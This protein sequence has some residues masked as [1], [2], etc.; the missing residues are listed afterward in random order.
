MI[1]VVLE[2]EAEIATGVVEQARVAKMAAKGVAGKQDAVFGQPG[3]LRVGPVQ[4][5]RRDELQRPS[6]QIHRFAPGGNV[7][8]LNRRWQRL[9]QRF[10]HQ[11]CFGRYM[12]FGLRRAPQQFGQRSGM[13]GFQMVHHHRGDFVVTRYLFQFGEERLAER[14]LDGVDNGNAVLTAHNVSV[15][16][17]AVGGVQDEIELP[18]TR[19]EH[20]DPMHAG[21]EFN[22][23]AVR[24]DGRSGWGGRHGTRQ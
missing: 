18:Q 11:R 13:V 19:I 22:R 24:V 16:G 8:A 3:A 21:R 14:F 17:G 9:E 2:A 10:Q 4:I 1:E 6:T 20:A 7:V 15:V 23:V 5:R 12:H